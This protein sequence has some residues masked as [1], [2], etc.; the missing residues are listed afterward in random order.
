MAQEL[1]GQ[2]QPTWPTSTVHIMGL[3]GCSMQHATVLSICMGRKMGLSIVSLP[4]FLVESFL[5]EIAQ[6]WC[7]LLYLSR[8]GQRARNRW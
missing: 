2:V 6:P 7:F 4:S 8:E 5:G 1:K 3:G